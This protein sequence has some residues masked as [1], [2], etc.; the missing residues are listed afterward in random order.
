MLTNIWE[1]YIS[2]NSQAEISNA[3]LGPV[4]DYVDQ[5]DGSVVWDIT[6]LPVR[7]AV[8]RDISPLPTTDGREGYYGA[9]NYNFWAS[10]LRDL[11]QITDWCSEKQ[12]EIESFLDV[13]CASGR[14]LRHIHY[15]SD[16]KT[17]I[18]C[19]INRTHVDW[20]A[21]NLPREIAVFQNTSIPTLPLPDASIDFISAFSVM[22]HIEAFDLTWL[23]E[24]RRILRPGGIAWLTFHGDRTWREIQPGW[25]LF[26][27]L[28]THP[29]YAKLRSAPE[30][31][32][33]KLVFRWHTDRSYSANVFYKEEYIKNNWGRILDFVE[34]IPCQPRFQDT[35][36]LRKACAI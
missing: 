28:T 35:A 4:K 32:S 34:I 19:D 1:N 6:K 11:F 5:A 9:N 16:I 13:G 7:V 26:D 31:P 14:L 25:P 2:I 3:I 17:I 24:F 10:G 15:Q 12:I 23:M 8:E 21:R 33:E 29:D 30:L 36:I 18:G 20:V 22:T 27:A